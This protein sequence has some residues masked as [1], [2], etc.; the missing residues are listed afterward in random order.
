MLWNYKPAC[1]V[2]LC[3][4]CDAMYF[5]ERYTIDYFGNILF[6]CYQKYGEDSVNTEDYFLSTCP[7]SQCNI[8][9]MKMRTVH[10]SKQT[11]DEATVLR[12]GT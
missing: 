3:A 8:I 6:Y 9:D 2:A 10:D 5:L 11:A 4:S 1:N 7:L 12:V